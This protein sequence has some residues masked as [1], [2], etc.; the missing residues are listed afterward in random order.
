MRIFFEY[1]YDAIANFICKYHA[2]FVFD[3]RI[4]FADN[5]IALEMIREDVVASDLPLEIKE[6][7]LIRIQRRIQKMHYD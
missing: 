1:V 3:L 6:Y 7:L 5:Q 4:S 2:D